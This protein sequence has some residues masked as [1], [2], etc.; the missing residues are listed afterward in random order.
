[1]STSP[2][3]ISDDEMKHL[4]ETAP[5]HSRSLSGQAEHWMRI[6]RAIERSPAFSYERVEMALRGLIPVTDLSDEEQEH[7]L[8][9]FSEQ[10]ATSS[11]AQ[12]AQY[13]ALGQRPH[14]VGLDEAGNLVYG[15][16]S[17]P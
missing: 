8:D 10:M 5:L 7:Y 14:A 13:A 15:S 4:R 16:K 17:P 6:G 2:L 11:A 1:M 12:R 9:Q 3:R